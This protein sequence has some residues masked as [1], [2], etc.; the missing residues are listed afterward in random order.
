MRRFSGDTN[1]MYSSLS[2]VSCSCAV[3]N[4]DGVGERGRGVMNI[5]RVSEGVVRSH[6]DFVFKTT[7]S[8]S[9]KGLNSFN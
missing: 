5:I 4:W 1:I 6:V 2:C 9:V 7:Q 8:F 3:G